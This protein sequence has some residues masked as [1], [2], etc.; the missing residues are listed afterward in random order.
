M[1]KRYVMPHWR[2][3]IFADIRRSDVAALLDAVED[4]HGHWVADSVLAVLRAL[5]SWFATRNDDYMPPFARGM[6][7]T[8]RQV[9]QRSRI[10]RRRRVRAVWQ[11]AEAAAASVPFSGFC[12]SRATSRESRDHEVAR[13]VGDGTWTIPKGRERRATPA[14]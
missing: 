12:C 10:L 14:C 8:P 11:T 13:R 5:A 6:R 1:L 9:R 4:K 2:D 7:R 3:R